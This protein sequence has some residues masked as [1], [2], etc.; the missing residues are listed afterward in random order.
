MRATSCALYASLGYERRDG[1]AG[2][3]VTPVAIRIAGRHHFARSLGCAPTHLG[4]SQ[5]RCELFPLL[6]LLFVRG[7]CCAPAMSFEDDL[8][9][10]EEHVAEARR[11]VQRQKG[12]II[13]LRA[14]GANTLDAQ[15][16]L[17]LLESNLRRLEE[18]RDR[19]GPTC[20]SKGAGP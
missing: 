7:A 8:R 5:G 1:R 14:A 3:S 18:H 15:R 6:P 20:G 13:R 12:L 4:P 10:V 2:P 16:V 19:L 17:W 11:F 9:R